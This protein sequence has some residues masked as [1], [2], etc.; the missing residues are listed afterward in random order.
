MKKKFFFFCTPLSSCSCFCD[1]LFSDKAFQ[2]RFIF[3][4]S[5]MYWFFLFTSGF[6]FRLECFYIFGKQM[7]K[8]WVKRYSSY[9]FFSAICLFAS[10]NCIGQLL[11][12]AVRKKKIR[13]IRRERRGTYCL[14][15]ELFFLII[16]YTAFRV[17]P[18]RI[19]KK[20]C[21]A[22]KKEWWCLS[23]Q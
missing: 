21:S 7:K 6:F 14:W 3:I 2:R 5:I 1:A 4:C 19:W 23:E 11:V 12:T 13:S 22:H 16:S 18:M 15:C 20:I 9:I 8:H 10:T 17:W